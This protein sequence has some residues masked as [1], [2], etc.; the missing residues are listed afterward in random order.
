VH[1]FGRNI[2]TVTCNLGKRLKRSETFQS[3]FSLY[4]VQN[5]NFQCIFARSTS[6]ETQQKVQLTLIGSLLYALSS[7]PK[8][9]IVRCP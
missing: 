5:A 6:T 1:V 3:V 7:D 2:Y 9:N 4:S 8:M